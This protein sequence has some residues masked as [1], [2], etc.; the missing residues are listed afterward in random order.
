MQ[1]HFGGMQRNK[2][3]REWEMEKKY[4]KYS[5][6]IKQLRLQMNSLIPF[7]KTVGMKLK[8]M[9]FSTEL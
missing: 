1:Q 7:L 2:K 9:L 8:A 4:Q 5:G 3:R 6:T